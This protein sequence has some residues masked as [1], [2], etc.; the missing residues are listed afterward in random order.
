LSTPSVAVGEKEVIL[1]VEVDAI[2]A[3]SN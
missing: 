3:A 1:V 2:F